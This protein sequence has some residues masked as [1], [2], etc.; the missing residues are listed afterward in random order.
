MPK[1]ASQIAVDEI[2]AARDELIT[3]CNETPSGDER[4]ALVRRL[5]TMN[6]RLAAA[7]RR[8]AVSPFR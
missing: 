4:D 7:E 6:D 1:T 5:E 3:L 8:A 2:N